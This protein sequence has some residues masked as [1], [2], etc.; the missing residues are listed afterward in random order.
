MAFMETLLSLISL[1]SSVFLLHAIVEG[2]KTIMLSLIHPFSPHSPFY[3][4]NITDI[5]KIDLLIQGTEGRMHHLFSTMREQNWNGSSEVNDIVAPVQYTGSFFYVAQVGIGSFPPFPGQK[6]LPY[7]LMVDTGSPLTWVQCKGCDP[8]IP[9]QQSDFPYNTSQSYRPIPCGDPTCP[10]PNLD[11]FQSFCGF[12]ISYGG[13][14]A[15]LTVGAIVRETLTFPS[16]F[17]GTESY[18]NLFLGCAFKNYNHNFRQPN[19]IGGILG[20]GFPGTHTYPFLN[21]VGKK[22]FSYCL[23]TSEHTN[24]QLYIG[25]GA[26]MVGPQVLSTPLLRGLQEQLYYVDLQDISIQNIHLRLQASFS[27]GSAI[28]TGC[29]MT[30]LVSNVYTRVRI[31]FVQYFA[32]FH[33]QPFND[34]NK[35]RDVPMLDLCFPIPSGFNRYPTM[36]FHF[37]GADLVVQPTGIFI[38]GRDYVCVAL[39]SGPVTMIGAFQQTQYKFSYDLEMGDREQGVNGALRF[40]PQIC[41]SPA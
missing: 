32:Q 21:Q 29:P 14:P 28:D 15:P 13:N 2:P 19:K 31:G 40:S 9:L 18:N 6:G 37:R 36:T 27:R 34:G 24:S 1:L 33:I 35:P 23:S 26:K 39:K 20:L 12:R 3:P 16:D 38:V 41:G 5:E 10:F 11:C 25:E 4:G 7:F 22:C 8:C 17:R 30:I